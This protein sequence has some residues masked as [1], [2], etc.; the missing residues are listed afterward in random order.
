MTRIVENLKDPIADNLAKQSAVTWYAA[1]ANDEQEEVRKAMR[2]A[3][4]SLHDFW[5][6]LQD[7]DNVKIWPRSLRYRELLPAFERWE[8]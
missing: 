5:E 2:M 7:I 6:C 1:L 8:G 3:R 4:C